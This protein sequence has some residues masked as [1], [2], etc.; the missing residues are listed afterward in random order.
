MKTKKLLALALAL[1]M[2]VCACPLSLAAGTPA[3]KNLILWNE[4]NGVCDEE[5]SL[6]WNALEDLERMYISGVQIMAS[7]DNSNWFVAKT[8]SDRYLSQTYITEFEDGSKPVPGTTYYFYVQYLGKDGTPGEKSNIVKAKY[9]NSAGVVSADWEI[10]KAGLDNFKVTEKGS[11]YDKVNLKAGTAV[12]FD[13]QLYTLTVKITA[14]KGGK[15]TVQTNMKQKISDGEQFYVDYLAAAYRGNKSGG[16]VS[17]KNGVTTTT[18]KLSDLQ[19]GANYLR[20]SVK[21]QGGAKFNSMSDYRSYSDSLTYFEAKHSVFFQNA[22]V[23]GSLDRNIVT[24]TKN[25]ISLGKA[26]KSSSKTASA[27]GTI[28]YY[29]ADGAKSWSNKAFAGGKS[30][31]LKGLKANTA[32]QIKTVNFV[33]ALSAADGKTVI[34]SKSGYSKAISVRTALATAPEIASIKVSGAKTD[35]I[36]V[37]GYWESDGDWHPAYDY[38]VTNY[39]ITITL[40]SAPKGLQGIKVTG[41]HRTGYP[42]WVKGTGKTFTVNA[43][44][45]G[46]AIGKTAKLGIST[47]T[48][49]FGADS[50]HC[51][52]SAVLKKNVTIR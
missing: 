41:A 20:F 39:K 27:S 9:A 18:L 26:Y 34:T 14:L 36:H 24:A 17:Q 48:N 52:Y 51:G 4:Q 7:T 22:P 44:A 13:T 10:V 40:K 33:K 50:G 35:K 29:K 2:I 42:V 23:A 19:D 30:M 43:S 3:A 25:A 45:T 28:L 32:Y 11:N 1:V 5:F 49:N 47:Y 21:H 15:A 12:T 8:S 46:N 6:H 37:N 31:T 38:T 16:Y